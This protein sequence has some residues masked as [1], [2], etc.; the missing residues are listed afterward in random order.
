[1]PGKVRRLRKWDKLSILAEIQKLARKMPLKKIS[2]HDVSL[3]RVAQN[4][5]GSWPVAIRAAGFAYPK[6]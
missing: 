4:R 2:G 1:M 3:C 6:A 5:F